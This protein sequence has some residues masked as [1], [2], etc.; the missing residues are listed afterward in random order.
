M[1]SIHSEN[2]DLL[3]QAIMSLDSVEE[4][5]KFFEDL[6]TVNELASMSQ[7]FHVARELS[8]G[9]TFLKIE[10]ETGASSATISRVNKCYNYGSGGYKIAIDNLKEDK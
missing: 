10:A 3:F 4:C 5:Y 2:T 1:I 9:K 6:C 8:A 7:R